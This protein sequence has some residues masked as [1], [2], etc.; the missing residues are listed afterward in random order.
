MDAKT[1]SLFSSSQE[2]RIESNAIC[3]SFHIFPD[4]SHSVLILH[5]FLHIPAGQ[6]FKNRR[7]QSPQR[8]PPSNSS[9]PTSHDCCLRPTL[10]NQVTN[11]SPFAQILPNAI[12]TLKKPRYAWQ[13]SFQKIHLHARLVK[14]SLLR[15][16]LR[17][18]TKRR[19]AFPYSPSETRWLRMLQQNT[20]R[21]KRTPSRENLPALRSSLGYFK[22]AVSHLNILTKMRYLETKHLRQCWNS[23]SSALQVHT[24]YKFLLYQFSHPL[25]PHVVPTPH[26]VYTRKPRTASHLLLVLVMKTG[27]LLNSSYEY[28]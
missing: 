21:V 4:E 17:L 22:L 19:W 5:A 20:K 23:Q 16:T 8:C 15:N 1:G 24:A 25:T 10:E 13:A 26:S 18:R 27:C 28:F 12:P 14:L 6:S 3:K 2:G 11:D 9:P 7:F